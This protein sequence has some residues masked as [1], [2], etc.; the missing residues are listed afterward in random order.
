MA[1]DFTLSTGLTTLA[2]QMSLKRQNFVARLIAP[3][4]SVMNKATTY[5]TWKSE[6]FRR[7]DTSRAQMSA[8][9]GGTWMQLTQTAAVLGEK[10]WLEAISESEAEEA[11]KFPGMSLEQKKTAMCIKKLLVDEEYLISALLAAHTADATIVAGSCWDEFDSLTSDPLKDIATAKAAMLPV[12][13]THIV[14]PYDCQIKTIGHPML[15]ELMKYTNPNMISSG[16][17]PSTILG[18]QVITPTLYNLSSAKGAAVAAETFGACYTD[19]VYLIHR[20]NADEP[21][22]DAGGPIAAGWPEVGQEDY[23]AFKTMIVGGQAG[24]ITERWSDQEASCTKVRVRNKG[25]LHVETAPKACYRIA[26]VLS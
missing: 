16:G 3:V 23:C 10:S 22:I 2:I 19:S 26:N 7:A 11:A 21:Q 6:E 5:A 9:P 14:F 15:K 4:L 1:S 13:P 20:G 17:W 18:M 25:L 8:G 24:L 12:I